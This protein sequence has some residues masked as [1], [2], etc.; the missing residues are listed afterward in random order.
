MIF[1]RWCSVNSVLKKNIKY[2]N[3][4]REKRGPHICESALY[5]AI[6]LFIQK[7]FKF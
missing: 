2:L 1:L 7:M 3:T 4:S 6:I 5:M